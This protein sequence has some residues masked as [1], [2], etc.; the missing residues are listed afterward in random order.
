MPATCLPREELSD[1]CLGTLSPDRAQAVADHVE[2][3]VNCE[4]TLR[5][6]EAQGDALL[7]TVRAALADEYLREPELAWAL[8]LAAAIV[9]GDAIGALGSQTVS[10]VGDRLRD[11]R[12]LAR[13]GQGGMGTVYK[14]IHTHLDKLVAVKL[15]PGSRMRDE[16]A[17]ARF[18]REMKAV[19]KLDHPN[20]VR[21]LDAGEDNG[22]HYLVMEYVEGFDLSLLCREPGTRASRVP[23]RSADVDKNAASAPVE[24]HGGRSL[25]TSDACELARQAA[26][27]LDY[28]H[29]HGLVH[30]DIKPSN[31]ILS[32]DGQ[33]KI[34]DLGLALLNDDS[35]GELTDT[36]QL[37]G[38]ADYMAPEQ[39]DDSHS[40]DGRADLYSLGCT[41]YR[42]LAGEPPFAAPTYATRMQKLMAHVTVPAP[43]LD[44]RRPDVDPALSALVKRL[45]AKQPSDRFATAGELAA[46][47]APFCDGANLPALYLA[48]RDSVGS[49]LGGLP[50]PAE[51]DAY[52][53]SAA[54]GTD[55]GEDGLPSLRFY[56]FCRCF[57]FKMLGQLYR[58]SPR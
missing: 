49:A 18:R 53:S 27:G 30:R 14:A 6:L 32:S 28:A 34:L 4:E 51:T 21:A 58:R 48:V 31:L 45:L 23:W 15:L 9:P 22:R 46:A 47:L 17:V 33:V 55:G 16:Q 26:L 13:L 54:H 36:Q 52:L 12:L 10:D 57:S 56:V 38:T 20:I 41:L 43:V 1:Y 2:Q 29:R 35:S 3:C 42:L 50:Q 19:G 39:A 37:M 40:V 5:Q 24:R 7:S 25:Q 8:E 44:S 11:Y